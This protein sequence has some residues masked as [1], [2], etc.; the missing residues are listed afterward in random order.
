[1]RSTRPCWPK[2]STG[3]PVLASTATRYPLLV[4]HRIRSS[5]PSVQYA[6]PRWAH[7]R[8]IVV[9]PASYVLGLYTQIVS[10]VRASMAAPTDVG[11]FR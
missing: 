9:V 10:P 11:M 5:A 1:M 3:R 2:L 8:V 4:P 6:T 7:R